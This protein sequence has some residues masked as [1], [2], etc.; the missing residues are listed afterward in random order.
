[1][2]R[3]FIALL[4]AST[5]LVLRLLGLNPNDGEQTVTE[6]EILMMVDAGEEKGLIGEN[7]KDMISNIFD[8]SDTTAV[9]VMTH[10]TD[11]HAVEDTGLRARRGAAFPPGGLLAHPGVP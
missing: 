3:P 4:T 7:A 1:M 11:V 8:F 2:C 9:E 10:R 5:N 6:E